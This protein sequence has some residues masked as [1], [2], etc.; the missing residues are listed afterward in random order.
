MSARE[1]HGSFAE[2]DATEPFPGI[3]R[4]VVEA[5]GATLSRYVFRPSGR[6]PQHVH[7]Q[8]QITIVERGRV[9][10]TFGNEERVAQAGD[11][12]SFPAGFWH[13]AQVLDEEA[14]LIDIFTPI[15]EDI[16]RPGDVPRG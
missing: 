10:F 9:R 4:R 6:F 1:R 7:P 8:E 13:G 12:V 16:L 15:R 3:E 14:V 5:D 2:L 11:V